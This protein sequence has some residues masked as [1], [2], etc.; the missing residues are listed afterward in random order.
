MH[1][2]MHNHRAWRTEA[3]GKSQWPVPT[4]SA[5]PHLSRTDNTPD[6]IDGV[7]PLPT[8]NWRLT[9]NPLPDYL[10]CTDTAETKWGSFGHC[11]KGTERKASIYECDQP[12][13]RSVRIGPLK[14][15]PGQWHYFNAPDTLQ[16][17][18]YKVCVA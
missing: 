2:V 7:E 18:G 1:N 4:N 10:Y 8:C 9:S 14:S 16:A 6:I 12:L 17:L 15:K 13:L 11:P 3:L 5:P